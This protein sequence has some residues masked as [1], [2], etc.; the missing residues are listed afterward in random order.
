MVWPYRLELGCD[1]TQE[2]ECRFQPWELNPCRLT[3]WLEMLLFSARMY[4]YCGHALQEIYSDCLVGSIPG[5]RQNPV[6]H[7]AAYLDDRARTKAIRLLKRIAS[8]F[9]KV[10]MAI[11]AETTTEVVREIENGKK[12]N[13]QWL[14]DKVQTIRDLADKEIRGKIFLYIPTERSKFLPTMQTPHVFGD[15]VNAA[16]P[17]TGYEISEAAWC[18]AL[19]RGTASVF[20][21]MRVLEIGL[22]AL[23][24]VFNVSLAHT[25]W[26]PAIEEIE[27]NI[28][29]MH[30]DQRWKSLPD[31]KEQ[32]EFYSQA[33]VHFGVIKDAWRNSTMHPRAKFTPD[34]AEVIFLGA[35]G[36]MQKLAEKLSDVS[37]VTK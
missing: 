3:D 28:R 11:T 32:R 37:G 10:G 33:A 19:A 1:E 26:A 20:H 35:K 2:Q 21:I 31:C 27:K 13:F 17:S 24:D 34:E 9:N 5:D 36:F 22:T 30:K 16:F 7:V 12:H 15:A 8:E 4:F 14:M 6:F 23:G 29:N 25:N 18:L